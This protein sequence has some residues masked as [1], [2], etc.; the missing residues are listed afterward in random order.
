MVNDNYSSRAGKII[1]VLQ[2]KRARGTH[3]E[4]PGAKT[5]RNHAL[6]RGL[7]GSGGLT[8]TRR[9]IT[10]MNTLR[11]SLPRCA[12]VGDDRLA[13]RQFE[14]HP[15]QTRTVQIQHLDSGAYWEWFDAFNQTPIRL[16][17]F[18]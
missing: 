14:I 6:H 13:F 4:D 1:V 8:A 3:A 15:T 17:R 7:F 11:P 16:E 2:P 10:P 18:S 12:N 9:S 5:S